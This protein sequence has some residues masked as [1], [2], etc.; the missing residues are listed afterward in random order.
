MQN[1]IEIGTFIK[2]IQKKTPKK[3]NKNPKAWRLFLD[4][5]LRA[6]EAGGPLSQY[7]SQVSACSNVVKSPTMTPR[8]F[9]RSVEQRESYILFQ[10]YMCVQIIFNKICPK[11][12][13]IHLC[14]M[15]FDL[16]ETGFFFI[17]QY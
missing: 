9:A 15:T 3:P 16:F 1:S 11:K 4:T 6:S 2:K 17:I 5:K 8:S 13:Q 7:L 14:E 10:D 12:K